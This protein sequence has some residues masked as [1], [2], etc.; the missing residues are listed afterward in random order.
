MTTCPPIHNYPDLPHNVTVS[1]R[2]TLTN[3]PRTTRSGY[4]EGDAGAGVP[5]YAPVFA[6]RI[7]FLVELL[8]LI[9]GTLNRWVRLTETLGPYVGRIPING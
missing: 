2:K 4:A 7:G 3:G 5:G 6:G 8:L 1:G 9:A